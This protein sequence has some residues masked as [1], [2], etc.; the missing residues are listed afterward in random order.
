MQS[1]IDQPQR[2]RNTA[3]SH[4][5]SMARLIQAWD[6]LITMSGAVA[7]I[8]IAGIWLRPDVV[9][10]N[11]FYRHLMMLTKREENGHTPVE[12]RSPEVAK[13]SR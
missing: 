1:P 8:V 13:T 9:S 12:V 7:D 4:R 3:T 11:P 6:W 10:V 2:S 5:S